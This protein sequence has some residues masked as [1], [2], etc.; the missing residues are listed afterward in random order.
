MNRVIG[1]SAPAA[2]NSS[3]NDS[4]AYWNA[5][6]MNSSPRIRYHSLRRSPSANSPLSLT[7]SLTTS[8]ATSGLVSLP[9][10]P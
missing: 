8:N 9:N 7:T 5:R 1:R 2:A 3:L 10:S 4:S 6:S